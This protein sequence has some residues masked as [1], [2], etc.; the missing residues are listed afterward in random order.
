[1][2]SGGPSRARS[3]LKASSWASRSGELE[4]GEG[5]LRPNL[6]LSF[7]SP[8]LEEAV[9]GD[10]WGGNEQR[11][12]REP[13]RCGAKERHIEVDFVL[14]AAGEEGELCPRRGEGR[15]RLS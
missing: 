13:V 3:S 10:V 8:I 4:G 5:A 9:R 1:M 7:A 11:L 15:Q 6:G 2:A 14:S 12:L